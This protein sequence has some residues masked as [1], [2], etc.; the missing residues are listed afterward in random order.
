MK[1]AGYGRFFNNLRGATTALNQH[2]YGGME[3]SQERMR[4]RLKVVRIVKKGGPTALKL[5]IGMITNAKQRLEDYLREHESY[6]QRWET[7]IKRAAAGE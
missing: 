5:E 7:L 1:P 3:H 2:Y 4:E 6:A